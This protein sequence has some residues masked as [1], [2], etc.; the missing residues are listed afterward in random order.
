MSL[1]PLSVPHR[2]A[3]G[4]VCLAPLP[5]FVRLLNVYRESISDGPGLRYS[6]YLSGCRHA[7][8]GCHNPESWSADAGSP[9]SEEVLSDIIAEIQS[10]PLL[11]GI[12]VSGGDPFYAPKELTC[13]LERLR[14]ETG[15][16]IWC[17]T[18]FTVEHLLRSEVHR[19]ALAFID[20]LVDGPFVQS[21]Y[22]PRLYFRG[23][24]NQRLVQIDHHIPLSEAAL[25]FLEDAF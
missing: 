6:I 3:P 11:D 1:E 7:C 2:W 14:Q 15:L 8:P 25:T 13:L 5:Y 23:S 4:F 20:V 12:T 9:L 16:K 17:Y 10:N 18:G 24:S 22:D 19:P 21:L